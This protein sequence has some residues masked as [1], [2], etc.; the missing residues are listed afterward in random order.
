MKAEGR[1]RYWLGLVVILALGAYGFTAFNQ[2]LA[3]YTHDFRD[4]ARR[5][6]EL[7][8]VPGVVDKQAPQNYDTTAGTF[9]FTL[10]DVEKRADRL[11]VRSHRVKPA[12]FDQASQ[13][14]CIGTFQNGVFEARQILVKCPSK[15]Q[16]KL[17]GAGST[18]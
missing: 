4:V 16:Q 17:T 12:N 5:S 2:S 7:L 3:T 13:V 9:E 6:G 1:Q 11:R 15:E 8:Q 10:L 18:S 14:V